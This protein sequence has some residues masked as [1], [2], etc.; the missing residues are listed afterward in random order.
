[1]FELAI[2]ST[3]RALAAEIVRAAKRPIASSQAF[4]ISRSVGASRVAAPLPFG[5]PTANPTQLPEHAG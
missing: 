5:A 3:T 4:T 1:L 2:V